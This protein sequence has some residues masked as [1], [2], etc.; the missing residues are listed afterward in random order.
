M[1]DQTRMVV[2]NTRGLDDSLYIQQTHLWIINLL[3]YYAT[4]L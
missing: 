3:L 1:F 4:V 2:L